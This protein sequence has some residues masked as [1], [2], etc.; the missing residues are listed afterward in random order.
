M[1]SSGIL[2]NVALVRTDGSEK[3]INPTIR[4][5]RIA[6]LDMLCISSQSATVA[7]H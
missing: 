1:P 4:V 3:R 5:T 2:N 6:E 7:S